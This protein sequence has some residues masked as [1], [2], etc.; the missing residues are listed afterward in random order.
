M[1]FQTEILVCIRAIS[2]DLVNQESIPCDFRTAVKSALIIRDMSHTSYTHIAREG[3]ILVLQ[4]SLKL[5]CYGTHRTTG[6]VTKRR[7]ITFQT[8]PAW[9]VEQRPWMGCHIHGLQACVPQE[10]HKAFCMSTGWSKS[11][12][13]LWFL[14]TETNGVCSGKCLASVRAAM[15]APNADFFQYETK[16]GWVS[17]GGFFFTNRKVWSLTGL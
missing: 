11:L 8:K 5:Q 12:V 13:F 10:A 1:D 17:N 15:S 2:A 7:E 6:A 3:H 16:R 9:E 14:F 4:C